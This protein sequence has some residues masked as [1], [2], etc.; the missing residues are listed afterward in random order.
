MVA[1]LSGDLNAEGMEKFNS[2]LEKYIPG[3]GTALL[4]DLSNVDLIDSSG[5]GALIKLVTRGR[6]RQGEVIIVAPNAFVRGVFETTR[7]DAWF[8]IS[9]TVESALE[10][11]RSEQKRP[12]TSH[13]EPRR[14]ETRWLSNG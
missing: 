10:R 11:L 3:I 13:V 9:A 14:T 7:L 5:L 4:V 8:D 1:G 6:L 12:A 2:S